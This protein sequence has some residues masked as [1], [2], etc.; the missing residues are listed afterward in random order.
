MALWAAVWIAPAQRARAAVADFFWCGFFVNPGAVENLPPGDALYPIFKR[1]A[2]R[3]ES[4][5]R[6]VIHGL[7]KR[8]QWDEM[9]FHGYV[10]LTGKADKAPAALMENLSNTYG[11]FLS[12]DQMISFEPDE[13][14]IFQDTFKTYTVYLFGALNL[15]NLE[16]RNLIYSRPFVVTWQGKAP[17]AAPR[18]IAYALDEFSGRLADPANA[19]TAKMIADLQRYFGGVGE[20][21]DALRMISGEWKDTYAVLPLCGGCVRSS[22]N[23]LGRA[24]MARLRAFARLYFNVRMAAF[25][26]TL[27][28]PESHGRLGEIVQTFVI[29]TKA[30]DV[31]FTAAP[32]AR[33]DESG[34]SLLQIN[35]PAPAHRVKLSL[36]YVVR[37]I[38]ANEN[39]FK[40]Q[41]NTLC[42]VL[43]EGPESGER[44]V[45]SLP[46]RF[47]KIVTGSR[48]VSDVYYF[49]SLIN[50]V[51]SGLTDDFFK[52]GNG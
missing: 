31:R 1:F 4:P 18:M 14:T 52:P 17:V 24:S 5:E 47:E 42:D 41:Y 39:A 2:S 28:C 34:Q 40:R 38:S 22:A 49:N 33:Y 37:Q 21:K 6:G 29:K 15:F 44:L 27:P 48:K 16:S 8:L 46:N 35:I 12:L 50:A 7:L 19:F 3:F 10:G 36:R 20:Q 26:Q 25:R 45:R 32:Y 51:S 11:F 23:D 9:T 13:I 43:V 30:G